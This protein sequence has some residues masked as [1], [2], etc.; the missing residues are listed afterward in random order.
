MTQGELAS[1]CGLSVAAIRDLEQ[2]RTRL[3]RQRSVRA[4]ADALSL[5]GSRRDEF[6]RATRPSERAEP[7]DPVR[8]TFLGILGPLLIRRG[9]RETSI[10]SLR[11]RQLLARLALS[12]N[13]T[14]GHDELADLLWDH[15]VPASVSG[16]LQTHVGRLRRALRLATMADE[17]LSLSATPGG[18]RLEATADTLDTLRFTSLV[19]DA[20]KATPET[21]TDLLKAA[22]ELCRGDVLADIPQ[23][24]NHPL[25]IALQEEC[26]GAAL[27]LADVAND[28]A[29]TDLLP[30]LRLQAAQNPLHEPLQARFMLALAAAGRRGEALHHFQDIRRRLAETLGIDPS[31]ELAAAHI[32]ILR[33]LPQSQ[34]TVAVS[35][36]SR[37]AQLP[38]PTGH[39][40]GRG[41]HM[42]VLDSL[43]A[44]AP[45]AT[46][47]P[48][49]VIGGGAGIGKTALAVHWAHRVADRFTDGQ[50]Y[51]DFTAGGEP[52]SGAEALRGLLPSLGV[53]PRRI[54]TND[55]ALIGLYRTLVHRRRM[56]I[57]LD[58]VRDAEQVRPLLPGTEG[59]MVVV[60]SRTVLTGLVTTHEAVLMPVGLLDAAESTRLLEHRLGTSRVD[61]EPDAVSRLVRLCDGLPLA[62]AIVAARAVAEPDMP[63]TRLAD[64]LEAS[65]GDL[66]AFTTAD[67]A[68]DIRAVFSWSYERLTA[69]A[70]RLFRY[71]SLHPPVDMSL[72]AAAALA[73]LSVARALPPMT[74]LSSTNL[75]IVHTGGRY[76]LQDLLRSYAAERCAV[77]ESRE[78]QRAAVER[79][80]DHYLHTAHRAARLLDPHRTPIRLPEKRHVVVV[81]ELKDAGQAR[82]W[83]AAEHRALI[84][85][86]DHAVVH[87]CDDHAWR[88]AW[89]LT[90]FL[91][92]QGFWHDW[93]RA[94]EV[95]LGAVERVG[96]RLDIAHTTR[97]LGRAYAQLGDVDASCR[98]LTAAYEKYAEL[99][100]RLSQARTLRNLA[101]VLGRHGRCRD[102]LTHAQRALRLYRPDD[103][104]AEYGNTLNVVGWHLA[105][106]GRYTEALSSCEKALELLRGTAD[107]RGMGVTWDSLGYIHHH[108][109]DP[110][111]SLE[112]YRAALSIFIDIGDRQNEAESRVGMA[113]T[114]RLL[115]RQDEA[116]EHDRVADEILR[117]LGGGAAPAGPVGP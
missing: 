3:P 20:R 104:P 83:F 110:L 71:L 4:L 107:S 26:I 84:S 41:S 55:A 105:L 94:Q 75:V 106:L 53:P 35:E 33:Q 52:L 111:R 11:Q 64:R 63:L 14:V 87:G 95:A 46:A 13:V 43:A 57:V 56:L 62:L 22:F 7:T 19:A 74:E 9:D 112:C 81:V 21:A 29:D 5:T 25:T 88:L 51:I 113:R 97:G 39:L 89:A 50:V 36:V 58:N 101:Y 28:T 69:P 49:V 80:L 27:V 59:C 60:T 54:P 86:I 48:I 82:A 31:D 72:E 34:E 45:H 44:D 67:E 8:P 85:V 117:E 114:Y 23:L 24:R 30:V 109:G 91:Q 99:G 70:A 100:R 68:S 108:C 1:S 96:D 40:V 102:A 17:P 42:A 37:P 61:G 73:G 116:D 115:G 10:T 66:S 103:D 98:H 2:Q 12:P 77:T 93:V 76:G 47:T 6:E 92:R 15:D 90:D 38:L 65:R 16:L 78:W 79:L 32:H 18:Y